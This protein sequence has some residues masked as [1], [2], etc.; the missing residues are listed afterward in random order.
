MTWV[1]LRV[2]GG[3]VKYLLCCGLGIVSRLLFLFFFTSLGDRN[4][5]ELLI[6]WNSQTNFDHVVHHK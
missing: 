5:K 4:T 3:T 1:F 2:A 6:T